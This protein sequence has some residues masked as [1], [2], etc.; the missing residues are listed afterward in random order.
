LATHP[1]PALVGATTLQVVRTVPEK[2][3]GFLPRGDFRILEA[4]TRALRSARSLVYLENQFL[5]SPEIVRILAEKLRDP[6]SDDFR[7]VVLLPATPNNGADDT[8]GQLGVLADAD[9]DAHRFLAAT[10]HSRTGRVTAPLYVHAKVG[11]VDDA[12]LT[13][14]SA[15]L[16]EHSLFNDSEMNV[17]ACDAALA[18]DTRLRLWAEHLELGVAD[19][20]GDPAQV[21]DELWRPIAGEQRSRLLD[22]APRTHRLCELPGVSRR[23]AALRGPLQ[24]LVVDG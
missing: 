24:S 21:V 10:I 6:P 4:Y 18:R 15:N 12:W 14:G 19:V 22:G 1:P 23:A 8:R 2:V 11:I 9:A 16:N 5:W 20:G 17:V 3:Y 13:V 7:L